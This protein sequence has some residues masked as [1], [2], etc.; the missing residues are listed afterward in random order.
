MKRLFYLLVGLLMNLAISNTLLAS[1]VKESLKINNTSNV[2]DDMQA[3][4]GLD[5]SIDK[6][7]QFC[8]GVRVDL[9]MSNLTNTTNSFT[10]FGSNWS[11]PAQKSVFAD[12]EGNTYKAQLKI[13]NTGKWTSIENDMH[14]PAGLMLRTSVMIEDVPQN[15]QQLALFDLRGAECGPHYKTYRASGRDINIEPYPQ[16]GSEGILC[17]MPWLKVD[18]KSCKRVGNLVHLTLAITNVTNKEIPVDFTAARQ[19]V[20]DA[21]GNVYDNVSFNVNNQ[22]MSQ[23]QYF[24]PNLPVNIIVTIKSM[25]VSLKQIEMIGLAFPYEDFKWGIMLSKTDIITP[26]QQTGTKKT[27]GTTRNNTRR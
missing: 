14:V 9:K 12:A 10:L 25:P 17:T 1:T 13:G 16:D 6:C 11:I 15:V 23:T 21:D 2:H 4:P 24:L 5:I 20:Y 19:G 27:T 18:L 26:T 8:D 7:Y 22:P 3:F